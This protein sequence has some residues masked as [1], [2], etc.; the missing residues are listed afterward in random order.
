[1]KPDPGTKTDPFYAEEMSWEGKQD[2]MSQMFEMCLLNYR[3][4]ILD[5]AFLVHTPG[6]KRKAVK[7]DRRRQ[8]FFKIHEKK[9]ARIYQRTIKQLL[10]RYPANRRC[11]P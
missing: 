6:I 1:M 10:K 3:L 11:A 8:D 4:I 7:T 9:N 5:G 2:K